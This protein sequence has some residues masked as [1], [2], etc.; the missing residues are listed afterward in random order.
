VSLLNGTVVITLDR[1]FAFGK[2]LLKLMH[3]R[4]QHNARLLKIARTLDSAGMAVESGLR[5]L[6]WFAGEVLTKFVSF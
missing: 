1:A 6:H 5:L 3:D 2:A 4:C